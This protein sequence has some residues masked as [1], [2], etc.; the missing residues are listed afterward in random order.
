MQ[1]ALAL[2]ALGLCAVLI[3]MMS[4]RVRNRSRA[5]GVAPPLETFLDWWEANGPFPILVAS[6]GGLRTDAAKQAALY[7]AGNTKAATLAQTPHGRGGAID[8]HPVGFDPSKAITPEVF[9]QFR[10][11]GEAAEARGL[12]WGGRWSRAFPPSKANP[13]GGDLPHVELPNWAALHYPPSRAT[14]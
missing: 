9:A 8:L 1:A 11:I 7:E 12:T 4:G 3:V 13:F 2:S 6:D 14:A 10:A 5:A